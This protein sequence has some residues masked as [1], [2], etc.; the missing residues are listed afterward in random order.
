MAMENSV[1]L[2]VNRAKGNAL[3]PI[4]LFH[5]WFDMLILFWI[6]LNE[7]KKEYKKNAHWTFPVDLG[8]FIIFH[9]I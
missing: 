4:A 9:T 7:Y 1:I 8:R 6:I 3:V 5:T 2:N